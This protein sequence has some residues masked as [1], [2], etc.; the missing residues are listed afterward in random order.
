MTTTSSRL[1]FL[2]ILEDVYVEKRSHFQ[3]NHKVMTFPKL[4]VKKIIPIFSYS[5]RRLATLVVTE[6]CPHISVVPSI[7]KERVFK[8]SILTNGIKV[9]TD[10]GNGKGVRLYPLKTPCILCFVF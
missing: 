7:P 9:L 8:E 6:E 10:S 5:S 2:K 4:L 3:K 1:N